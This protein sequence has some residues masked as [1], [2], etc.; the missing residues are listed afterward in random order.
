MW[1]LGR[2]QTA[3]GLLTIPDRLSPLNLRR[4]A[5]TDLAAAAGANGLASPRGPPSAPRSPL[6]AAGSFAPRAGSFFGSLSTQNLLMQQL[7]SSASVA[8]LAGSPDGPG[9]PA[10]EQRRAALAGHASAA[11]L[12]ELVANPMAN[13]DGAQPMDLSVSVGRDLAAAAALQLPPSVPLTPAGSGALLQGPQSFMASTPRASAVQPG[14]L[15]R[16]GSM[17]MGLGLMGQQSLVGAGGPGAA[18]AAAAASLG[19][20]APLARDAEGIARRLVHAFPWNK[21]G[22]VGGFK[23]GKLC[24]ALRCMPQF[25]TSCVHHAPCASTRE[26]TKS[27]PHLINPTTRRPQAHLALALRRREAYL[28]SGAATLR[29]QCDWAGPHTTDFA[30]TAR[31]TRAVRDPAVRKRRREGLMKVG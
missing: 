12:T 29:L 22:Q 5:Q 30:C 15:S 16:Y 27:T 24:F 9:D 2:G 25:S 4:P 23:G 18:A 20:G 10:A 19:T 14:M 21:S 8:N 6:V 11:R 26:F 28:P 1:G 3:G 7:G 13:C 31:E 17:E